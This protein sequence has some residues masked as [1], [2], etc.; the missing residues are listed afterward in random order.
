MK[1]IITTLAI[2]MGIIT[3]APNKNF[4]YSKA[5]LEV[6]KLIQQ[7]L[8]QSALEKVEEIYS[9][10][11]SEKNDPQLV[12]SIIYIAR[13]S[14]STDEKGIEKSIDRLQ[15]IINTSEAPVRQ[16]TASYLGE[17]YLK[18]F[19]NYRWEIAQRSEFS[20]DQGSDFRTWTTQQFLRTVEKW[21]LFSI[22]NRDVLKVDVKGFEEVLNQYDKD[23]IP[24]RPTLY[25]VLADRAFIFFQNY[26]SY[27]T[28]NSESFQINKESYFDIGKAFVGAPLDTNDKSSAKYKILSLYQD[29]IGTQIKNKNQYATGEYDLSRLQYVF[30]QATIENKEEV[31]IKSLSSLLDVHKNIDFSTEIAAVWATQV[32]NFK[33]DSLA[34]NKAIKICA[35]AIKAFPNSTGAAKC[36]NLINE[37]KK[38]YLQLY[39]EQVYPSK[40][41]LLFALDYNNVNQATVG[42]VKLDESFKNFNQRN[43]EEI[44][45]YLISAKKVKEQ[46]YKLKPSSDFNNQKQEFYFDG[47]NF[48]RYALVIQNKEN[49]VKQY[50]IFNVSDLSY[51]SLMANGKRLF[52][53][54]DRITGLPVKDA[55][56]TLYHQNYNPGNRKYDFVK[57]GAYKSDANGKVTV[58]DMTDRN[59]KVVLSK[60]KDKL[61]L[62]QY[63]YNYLR[64]E[65]EEYK[66][67]EFYTDRSIYR[68]GQVV[69][70]KAILLKNDKKQVPSLIKDVNV[71]VILRDANYQDISRQ[72]LRSNDFGS[73]NGSFTL[74]I[75]KLNGNFTLEV[76]SG[77]GINGQK[78]IQVEE[79]KRP[80]FE[81]KAEAVAGDYKLNEKI[82]ITGTA[83]TLAGTAVDGAELKYKVTRAA[84]FPGWWC[85]WRMP[86]P[87]TEFIVDQGARMTDADGK[88][89]FDFL[90]IPDLKVDK[91]DG[92]VFTY[93]IEIEVTDQ[94]GETRTVTTSV[95]VGYA[96]FTLSSNLSGEKDAADLK[97]LKISA[98]STNGQILETKGSF[99]ISLLKEPSKVQIKKYWDGKIHFPLSNTLSKKIFPH[100]PTSDEHDF[101]TWPI[102]RDVLSGDFTTKD[103]IS[104]AS[105]LGAG[106]YKVSFVAKDKNGT[107]VNATQYIVVTD[108][109]KGLFPK[110]DFLFTKVNKTVL[111][112]E[113]TLDIQLGTSDKSIQALII[114]EKDG[115]ILLEESKNIV[116]QS[117]IK[118]LIDESHR[119]GI[120]VKVSYITQ[121]RT[122][123]K[124]YHIDIPWTNKD[125]T[126]KYE[127]FRDKTL[128][129]SQEEYRIKISG[130]KNDKI[131]A[132]MVAAMYD[133]SLDQFIGHDWKNR[134]YPNSY[135]Q[136]SLESY[137]FKLMTG[138]YH[139]YGNK[140][141]QEIKSLV[142]PGLIALMDYYSYGGGR[143]DVAMMKSMRSGAP[144]PEAMMGNDMI[145]DES[146]SIPA[147]VPT[148]GQENA[149]EKKVSDVEVNPR[150]NLNETVFFFPELK[151]DAEGNVILK[152]TINEA[153]TKWRLMSFAHTQDFMTGYDERFV[154]TQKDLMVFP[155][156]PRFLRDGDKLSF[157][158]KVSNLSQGSLN[159]KATLQIWDAVAMKEIT[160]ELIPGSNTLSFDIEKGRS[161]GLSW[162]I[163]VPESKYAAITY[164][165]TAIAD[166]HTDAE[167][168][169]IPVVSNRILVTE[170]MP[171]WI[172][173]NTTR[174]FTFNAFKNNVS[175]TK[176]DFK[177]TFE[178]TSNPVWYAIQALPY[179][180]QTNNV[181]TQSI[182][183]KMYA[184]VLA[185][186]IA[187][188]H[189]KIKSVF[190]QW[191]RKD[192]DALISNLSKNEEL[193]TAMLEETP[194]VR[195]AMSESEQK[196]NI[197]ILFDLNRLADER[198]VAIQKMAERQLSNGG[199]PW[200]SG[201]RDNVFTTQNIMENIGHLYHLGALEINDPALTNIVSKALQY[202]DDELVMRYDKLRENVAKYGGKME[203]DHLDDLSVHYLY[204]KTFF[205]HVNPSSASKAARTYYY[206]QAQKYWLKRSLYT[207]AMI[208]LILS[209]NEDKLVNNI[210]KSLR[211][212]SFSS[213]E[214]GIYWNEGN[215]FY[216]YQLPIERHA[217]MIELF[218]E[219]VDNKDEADKMKVWLLKNKQTN[220]WKTSKSTAAAIYALLLQGENG[221]ISQWVTESV[222]PVIMVGAELINTATSQTESGTGYIKKSWNPEVILKDMATIKVTNNNKSIAWGAAYYQYFEQLD[223]IKSFADTPLKLNKKLY[224]V[225][226]TSKG[227]ELSEIDSDTALKPGDMLKIRIELRVD[228]E[229]EYVLMKDMRASGIEPVNVIS[230]YKY[231]GQLGY[232]ET[233]KDLS[234]HFYFA[235]LPKGTFVFEY[236]VRVVHKGDFSGG[237]TNIECMYA[238]EFSS[239]SEGN[240]IVVR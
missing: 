54:V 105:K 147:A 84:R 4:D 69:Y 145:L 11:L 15:K 41:A 208:G 80:T 35:D 219:V 97:L 60:G 78:N 204:V 29:V 218:S 55:V 51:S 68:P 129:G 170:T 38:P 174:S 238:P 71:E 117:S 14:V 56:L 225:M 52:F 213:D 155:N 17:L 58:A 115:K 130:S 88:F 79:Y 142:F 193:K 220:H 203:D 232:Y 32:S 171:F 122:Y 10:A 206:G 93:S 98:T 42:I 226:S 184:N 85:W 125:L 92:P 126:I 133:A 131:A 160:G 6:E 120:H 231:Q 114:I 94:R 200:L 34:N 73:I 2:L 182:V 87:G 25:E 1:T 185:S 186:K 175:K 223:Q 107:E 139:N 159:G 47:L 233:T 128:P 201:G 19:D 70:Y 196:R 179:I 216:W 28:E 30:S 207:Q 44:I 50:L 210:I 187:N 214:M 23:A 57:S 217:L 205:K 103:D 74:P 101:T 24:F 104:L 31:Y 135:T 116:K 166:N 12:K 21:Y 63:H 64:G 153:L 108:F 227:D 181:S 119:G 198:N 157:S 165:V 127:T 96:A 106:V 121:N 91:K 236:P 45:N 212:K 199:F 13:L 46:N 154:Q 148:S 191:S 26:D 9:H 90:A 167:E 100:Y 229:M 190:D 188:A 49:D 8:P 149:S 163:N 222:Q 178:Y 209:R 144:E 75:G 22:E 240:R 67:A 138:S 237:I 161:Q 224:K 228:R 183:D 162:N 118:W 136:I 158:A 48:G 146:V 197:A 176:K 112:P 124:S 89:N 109:S 86:D 235:F 76:V 192:K 82:T 102:S 81:V 59:F 7:G 40:K 239:H 221:N 53:V 156:A 173:G 195:Q 95:S 172:K 62:D 37:I 140:G 194:W 27:A 141:Y 180:T 36:Q 5:W 3:T 132:E 164:R 66:F 39:A 177:Y 134:F 113:Q 189:P 83:Q 234:T 137:G 202:M 150:K 99:K 110:S 61:D 151:T 65:S 72:S 169:T 152:F 143:G 123:A 43:Q 230:E 33:A 18:Y 215:G 16:I 111:E 77:S 168:N 20:G 211:E